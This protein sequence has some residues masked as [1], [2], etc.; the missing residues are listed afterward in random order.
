MLA[1]ILKLE[2]FVCV[3]YKMS[4]TDY[5]ALTSIIHILLLDRTVDGKLMQTYIEWTSAH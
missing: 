4:D 1:K 3:V 2:I 5:F